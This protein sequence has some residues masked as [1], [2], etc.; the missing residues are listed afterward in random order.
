AAAGDLSSAHPDALMARP[1]L[2]V[3]LSALH[4]RFEPGKEDRLDAELLPRLLTLAR[5]A[6]ARN[7]PLTFDTEEQD[8]L[9]PT[10][11]LFAAAFNDPALEG[12]P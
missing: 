7:V 10:A 2:S 9:E 8:R 4:P 12:W 6:R 5:A 11:R 3:K 1:S